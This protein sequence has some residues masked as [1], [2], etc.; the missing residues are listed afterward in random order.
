MSAT[1]ISAGT[2]AQLGT[3]LPRRQFWFD[4]LMS[5]LAEEFAPGPHRIN[6][7][8]RMA[9]IGTVGAA[10]MGYDPR[11]TRGTKP[12]ETCDNTLLLA[13]AL[14]VG[15]ADLSRIEVR[16]APVAQVRYQFR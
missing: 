14:G 10:V 2:S 15:S 3:K 12:F 8:L 16:G 6:T 4:R 11:A 13:E 5:L 9:L 1:P 7:A